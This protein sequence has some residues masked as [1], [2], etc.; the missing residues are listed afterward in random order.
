MLNKLKLGGQRGLVGFN[1]VVKYLGFKKMHRWVSDHLSAEQRHIGN[2]NGFMARAEGRNYP[3]FS[4]ERK[5]IK[6]SWKDVEEVFGLLEANDKNGA[7]KRLNDPTVDK[8]DKAAALKFIKKALDS[9][10]QLSNKDNLRKP[11]TIDSLLDKIIDEG[12]E[13]LTEKELE[14][15]DKYN[16]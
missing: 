10:S 9:P 3:A 8:A 5:Q 1:R 12:L 16:T 6:K 11:F 13:S 7:F 15:L 2:I 14:F 4:K